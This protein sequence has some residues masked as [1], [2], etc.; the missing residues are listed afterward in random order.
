M[1]LAVR[2]YPLVNNPLDT[3]YN[4]LLNYCAIDCSIA[5]KRGILKLFLKKSLSWQIWEGVKMTTWKKTLLIMSVALMSSAALAQTWPTK[6]IKLVI[7]YPPGGITDSAARVVAQGLQ[8]RLGQ[9][10][11]AENK[12][13]AASRIAMDLVAKS[14]ADGYTLLFAPTTLATNTALYGDALPFNVQ[15]D[16]APVAHVVWAPYTLMVRSSLGIN[17]IAELVAFAKKNPGKV[18]A[19]TLQGGSIPN[20]A[21][22][23][24]KRRTG[25][26]VYSVPYK[27]TGEALTD[28]IG[29]QI[30][31]Y[32]EGRITAEGHL[33]SGKL[34]ALGLAWSKRSPKAPEVPTF[35]E[36]GYSGFEV[37]S[38]FGVVAPAQTPPQIIA[39]LNQEIVAVL[40]DSATNRRL[41]DMDLIPT[42]T[43]PEEFGRI[44]R[45]E[46][47]KWKKLIQ[48]AGIKPE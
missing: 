16:F 18:N 9:P 10:V 46:T 21:L 38:W 3:T 35:A 15:K 26:D 24:F 8:S 14:P 42:G 44:V 34:K 2:R 25:A 6:P 40:K 36:V 39:K 32:F 43:S 1:L 12:P 4:S 45:D 13:G 22:E 17:T 20:L 7:P 29:G 37:A 27:G 31:M 5:F 28:L 30:D 47:A 41:V 11:I 33:K 23:L 19:G 48:D